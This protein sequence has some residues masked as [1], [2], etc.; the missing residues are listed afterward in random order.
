MF[1]KLTVFCKKYF[2][3]NTYIPVIQFPV[4]FSI[5]SRTCLESDT[6]RK[7]SC[8]IAQVPLYKFILISV[9]TFDYYNNNNNNRSTF[10][11]K[12]CHNF[13]NRTRA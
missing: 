11:V 7:L 3:Y 2:V 9:V 4:Y 13:S 6:P 5:Y 12:Q 1:E 8:R 10:N